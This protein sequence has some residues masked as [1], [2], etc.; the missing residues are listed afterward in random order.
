MV[1]ENKNKFTFFFFNLKEGWQGV[2]LILLQSET[3][4]SLME[5]AVMFEDDLRDVYVRKRR[6]YMSKCDEGYM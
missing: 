3:V 5:D 4:A 1:A 6:T 2:V